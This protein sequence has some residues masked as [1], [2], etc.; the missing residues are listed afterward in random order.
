MRAKGF[1]DGLTTFQ[2]NGKSEEEGG[3]CQW[4]STSCGCHTKA[5]KAGSRYV[6]E[7]SCIICGHVVTLLHMR[8]GRCTITR[9]AAGMTAV[10]ITST[11]NQ[12]LIASPIHLVLKPLTRFF[13]CGH[14][15][16]SQKIVIRVLMCALYQSFVFGLTRAQTRCGLQHIVAKESMISTDTCHCRR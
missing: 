16:I 11:T 12:C 5:V 14:M 8:V 13:V 3:A 1:H 9:S 2:I 4:R 15:P 7:I 6:E 10:T